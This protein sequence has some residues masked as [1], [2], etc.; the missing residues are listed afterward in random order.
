M[1]LILY[2]L[3]GAGKN[4][5]GRLL[6]KYADGHFYDADDDLTEEMRHYIDNRIPLTDS[7]RDRYYAVVVGRIAELKAQHR[8]LIVAQA[9]I[10][11]RHRD[12]IHEAHPEAR[13]VLIE[14]PRKLRI[15]RLTYRDNHAV[16]RLGPE[17]ADVIAGMFERPANPTYCIVNDA[18]S[19]RILE[20]STAILGM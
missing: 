7:V 16:G 20:Q 1:L 13:F 4:Y 17:Y 8:R 11:Q 6:A 10:R 3:P 5:V 12:M 2:G 14:A 18:G 19:E 9:L 15:E